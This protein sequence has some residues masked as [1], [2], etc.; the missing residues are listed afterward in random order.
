MDKIVIIDSEADLYT[1]LRSTGSIVSALPIQH[2][3][4]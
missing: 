2:G 4:N 1:Q 3:I